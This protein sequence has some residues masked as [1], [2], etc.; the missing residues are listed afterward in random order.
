MVTLWQTISDPGQVLTFWVA[1]DPP[2]TTFDLLRW[3]NGQL[4]ALLAIAKLYRLVR[5]IRR[6]SARE[7]VSTVAEHG[8]EHD[9]YQC[10]PY[11]VHGQIGDLPSFQDCKRAPVTQEARIEPRRP[12]QV[13]EKNEILAKS[14]HSVG[15]EAK[16]GDAGC[17]RRE[18]HPINHECAD[19]E[20]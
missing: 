1:D 8:R 11:G 18:R 19:H 10:R 6:C 14:R 2:G 15:S 16:L 5:T 17:N 20:Q 4:A 9:N 13:D 12:R 7:G 3:F